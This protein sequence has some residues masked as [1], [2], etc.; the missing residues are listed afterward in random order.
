[1]HGRQGEKHKSKG[2]NGNN[3]ENKTQRYEKVEPQEN[4]KSTLRKGNYTERKDNEPV[5]HKRIQGKKIKNS[6]SISPKLKDKRKDN[7]SH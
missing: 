7:K 5:D 3:I 6:R 1:M 4:S 2:N